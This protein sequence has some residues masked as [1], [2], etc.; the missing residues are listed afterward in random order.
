MFLAYFWVVDG[1]CEW[2]WIV[3]GPEIPSSSLYSGFVAQFLQSQIFFS[4]KQCRMS[5]SMCQSAILKVRNVIK[6]LNLVWAIVMT[7]LNIFVPS[8]CVFS[9]V[10]TGRSALLWPDRMHFLIP[11]LE[12]TNTWRSSMSAS[13][14]VCICLT[15]TCLHLMIFFIFR[16]HV[17]QSLF[18]LQLSGNGRINNWFIP[19]F[20]LQLKVSPSF[21]LIHSYLPYVHV[22]VKV[23]VMT[24]VT[25]SSVINYVSVALCQNE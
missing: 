17:T 3:T 22:C 6:P 4:L 7:P 14:T 13:H 12:H 19:F 9:G 18:F 20:F 1:Y 2:F 11:A 24:L 15:L 16:D 10:I 23:C 21:E 8:V 5:Y 25:V